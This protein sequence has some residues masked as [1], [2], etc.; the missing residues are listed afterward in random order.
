MNRRNAFLLVLLLSF[1]S[2]SDGNDEIPD[3]NTAKIDYTT[4]IK[5]IMSS[6]CTS[7]HG[8]PTSNGA[9]MSLTTYTE[10]KDAINT[11]GL[12]D[13]INSNSN[14]MPPTGLM[15]SNNRTLIQRWKDD[16]FLE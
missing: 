6:N 12:I 3:P 15:T 10:V 16:G 13:R 9:P 1:L 8:I 4:S 7:C 5:T 2:C 14:P 11:K